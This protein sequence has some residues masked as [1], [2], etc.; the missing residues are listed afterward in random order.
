MIDWSSTKER[1]NEKGPYILSFRFWCYSRKR[2]RGV[3]P[4]F[5]L[6]VF[7]ANQR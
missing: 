5:Q 7:G 4:S 3:S 2:G 1:V 6:C